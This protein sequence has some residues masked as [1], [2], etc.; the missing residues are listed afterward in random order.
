MPS[1]IYSS[2]QYLPWLCPYIFW[3]YAL[4]NSDGTES[5][6]VVHL[7]IS[8]RNNR[9]TTQQSFMKKML[10]SCYFMGNTTIFFLKSTWHD[11]PRCPAMRYTDHC[12]ILRRSISCRHLT[13]ALFYTKGQHW[14]WIRWY[15]R[16]YL[17]TVYTLV[18]VKHNQ[19]LSS[20]MLWAMHLL[21]AVH[22]SSALAFQ[23]LFVQILNI[24]CNGVLHALTGACSPGIRPDNFCLRHR[25]AVYILSHGLFCELHV[26]L[27]QL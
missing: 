7:Y 21:P 14:L 27:P 13:T 12:H 15:I 26:Y 9:G 8:R 1:L 6:P 5:H 2:C 24:Q 22:F 11:P 19:M 10:D 18:N 17:C 23:L 25:R 4:I 20:V 16:P 3:H